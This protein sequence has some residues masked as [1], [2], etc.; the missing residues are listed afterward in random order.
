MVDLDGEELEDLIEGERPA[1]FAE[2]EEIDLAR[3]ARAGGAPAAAPRSATPPGSSVRT[4]PGRSQ[5][6]GGSDEVAPRAERSDPRQRA[7]GPNA[8]VAGPIMPVRTEPMEDIVAPAA[9]SPRGSQ[10]RAAAPVIE[11]S[12]P[13]R[14]DRTASL[15]KGAQGPG[16]SAPAARSDGRTSQPGDSAGSRPDGRFGLPA[17]PSSARGSESRSGKRRGAESRARSRSKLE[18]EIDELLGQT[19]G[20]YRILSLIGEGGMGRVYLAEHVKLGRRVALKLLRPEYA[21]KRDAVSRF[22]KEAQAVNKIGHENIVDITDFVELSTGETYIIMELLQGEDLADITRKGE[23]PMPLHR[24]MQ[25]ALQVCDALE[26]AHRVDIV[27]RDLKPDN[28]FIVNAGTKHD[29]VKLLDFGVAKLLGEPSD[30]DGWHTAAGSVIGTPAY[31]SPEQ[32]SGIPVDARSDIYSLGAILYEL[33]TGHP[34]FRAKSFGEY[35]VK[36]MNDDPVP[37][38]DLANAPKI[39]SSLERVILRCLE[40]DPNKRYQSVVELRDDL[41]RATATV[42]T[43]VS[44]A[45]TTAAAR[46]VRRRRRVWIA[47][48]VFVG[49]AG[50]AVGAFWLASG[51]TIDEVTQPRPDP[52]VASPKVRRSPAVSTPLATGAGKLQ[53]ARLR[54]ETDPKGADVYRRDDMKVVLGKTPLDLN[55]DNVGKEVEFVFRLAG[56]EDAVERVTVTDNA[57]YSIPLERKHTPRT[58]G[59]SSP[60]KGASKGKPAKGKTSPSGKGG[61]KV[62]VV[63]PPEPAPQPKPKAKKPTKINPEDVVDPFADQK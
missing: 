54:L 19:L 10:P 49:V 28:I 15:R 13:P 12:A 16:A 45:P 63:V 34:V 9:S 51:L 11:P 8:A 5:R 7:S 39:P 42:Q 4:G 41:A 43:V 60:A 50:L 57:V 58:I 31:M 30:S 44:V 55:V 3:A 62:E 22:F 38:R 1:P 23:G 36:H 29:F 25:I 46:P 26:A 14:D 40:K 61:T 2:T 17:T 24:A 48:P 33:F 47:V 21:V 59:G 37:P 52:V 18:P 20:S 56:Y 32:A 35:V 53:T 6:A 27:H